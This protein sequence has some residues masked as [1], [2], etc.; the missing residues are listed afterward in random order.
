MMMDDLLFFVAFVVVWTFLAAT[1]IYWNPRFV[2]RW[3]AE[4]R[5][6]YEKRLEGLRRQYPKGG[7]R[8]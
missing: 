2:G 3:L 7:D 8:S 6:A 4:I 1:F 5:Y